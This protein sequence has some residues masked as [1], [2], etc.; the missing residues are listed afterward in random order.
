M[1]DIFDQI[2]QS[3]RTKRR[4]RG[5]KNRNSTYLAGR[6]LEEAMGGSGRDSDYEFEASRWLDL[7][8]EDAAES[9]RADEMFISD[10]AKLEDDYE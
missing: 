1:E 7:D 2:T 6:A 5:R 9:S 3:T 10:L 4:V 8:H